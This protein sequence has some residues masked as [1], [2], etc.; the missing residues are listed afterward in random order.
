MPTIE[1]WS[2]PGPEIVTFLEIPSR[3]AGQ[4]DRATDRKSNSITIM[5]HGE[6]LTQ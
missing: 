4:G 6:C 2:A 5:G 3:T 1:S